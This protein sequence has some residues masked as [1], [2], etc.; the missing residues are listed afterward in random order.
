MSHKKVCV[1]FLLYSFFSKDNKQ[2]SFACQITVFVLQQR[3]NEDIIVQIQPF[4]FSK[5]KSKGTLC[6]SWAVIVVQF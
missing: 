1:H 6:D 3:K 5:N 2:C 4:K